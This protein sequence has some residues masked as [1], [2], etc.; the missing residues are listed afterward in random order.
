MSLF[1]AASLTGVQA[2]AQQ[3]GKKIANKTKQQSAPKKTEPIFLPTVQWPFAK[4][5]DADVKIMFRW[6]KTGMM[7]G[8]GLFVEPILMKGNTIVFEYGCGLWFR[9][10]VGVSPNPETLQIRSDLKDG[11]LSLTGDVDDPMN[12]KRYVPI[13]LDGEKKEPENRRVGPSGVADFR[14]I[15]PFAKPMDATDLFN[16]KKEAPVVGGRFAVQP[17]TLKLAYDP[18]T[19]A[20]LLVGAGMADMP[21][22]GMSYLASCKLD[23]VFALNKSQVKSCIEGLRFYQNV[24][25]PS[26]AQKSAQEKLQKMC[27]LLND[28][29]IRWAKAGSCLFDLQ[30]PV[31]EG[32]A[33]SMGSVFAGIKLPAQELR[34]VQ[35]YKANASKMSGPEKIVLRMT[36]NRILLDRLLVSEWRAAA[37]AD[38]M[39][40]GP[41]GKPYAKSKIR[42]VDLR[43][44]AESLERVYGMAGG[45]TA[46]QAKMNSFAVTARPTF[47]AWPL[48][49]PIKGEVPK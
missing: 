48:M 21:E 4:P 28:G 37:D 16:M 31:D 6:T 44:L 3:T 47:L 19:L 40:T 45:L 38:G 23:K 1:L 18:Q 5:D 8:D 7:H 41:T 33:A 15:D 34:L 35:N 39:A 9:S 11:I 12:G 10:S 24:N 49:E 30:M 20:S 14:G 26:V 22:Y 42:N 32:S 36:I 46:M 13:S 25:D 29:M 27:E 17:K 43:E 2:V